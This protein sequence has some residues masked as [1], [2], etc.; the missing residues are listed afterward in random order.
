MGN[1]LGRPSPDV[2]PGRR[3]KKSGQRKKKKDAF[4]DSNRKR[5]EPEEEEEEEGPQMALQDMYER[6]PYRRLATR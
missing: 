5:P 6:L 1:L 4:L 2:Q 3:K